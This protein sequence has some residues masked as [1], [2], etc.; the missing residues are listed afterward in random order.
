MTEDSRPVVIIGAGLTGLTLATA[1]SRAGRPVVVLEKA[2]RPGGV[3]RS[4]RRDGFLA[5][6]S[7][8]S[9]MIKAREV[10]DFIGEIGL[11]DRLVDANPIANKRFLMRDGRVLAMPMSMMDAVA[12]PLYSFGAKLRLLKEPFVAPAPRDGDESVAG[13]VS[14]RMGREFLDYGIAA[15][16]SG[17]FAG[18]PQRLSIRHAFPKVWNLEA[19]YGSLIGGAVKLMR[20]RKRQGV[21]PYKSRIVSFRDGLETLTSEMAAGLGDDLRLGARLEGLGPRQE[22][23]RVAW[24]DA[25][26]SHEAN[27]RAVVP[28][29]PLEAL[30]ALPWTDD[31]AETFAGLPSLVH[32]PVTTLSLGYRRDQVEHSMDGFGMLAPLV[33]KRQI[34]GA[35]FSSTLFPDR[36]PEGHVLFMVFMGGAT[37]PEMAAKTRDEA[38]GIAR[39]ELA[40]MF[41]VSGEPV[42]VNHR[43]WPAAIPQY[44]VGHGE[45]LGALGSIESLWP[46]LHVHGNF[47]G[48]PGVND[49]VA[50]GLSL[51]AR[52]V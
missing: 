13:F 38:V 29:V 34:L 17:I 25:R 49:C 44:N 12:T 3:I 6:D 33:E 32:P 52:L 27:A 31:L 39:G 42:F 41:G 37:R 16:V 45:F 15:L 19:N 14:R 51:A 26:G 48:G 35:I 21:Q 47:R 18:D 24:S 7:A 46:G 5:E 23:W 11:N 20:E 36:A 9:M 4:I 30:R 28:T 10:E 22:G 8:N 43:H 40:E 2:E 50:S 1:L